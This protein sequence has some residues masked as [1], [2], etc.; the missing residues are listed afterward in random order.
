MNQHASAAMVAELRSFNRFYTRQV[1]LVS[2]GHLGSPWSLTEG[3][4][5]YE[6]LSAGRRET[7][8]L[9][10]AL[11]IDPAQL[12]RVL[13]RL[14]QGGLLTRAP[15]PDDGRRQTVALTT[16]GGRAAALLDDR[17]N[18]A[19]REQLD[20]LRPA[21]RNRL[22]SGMAEIRRILGDGAGPPPATVLLRPVR[23]GDLGWVVERHAVLY[24]AEYGWDHT[25]EGLI[26]EVVADYARTADPNRVA[27]WIAEL[28]GERVGSVFCVRKDDT[29]AKL[30]LLL[31]E[32]AARGHRIGSRLVDTCM[33]F[34]RTAGYK[35]MTL[36]TNDVLSSARHIYQRA[37]FELVHSEEHR[38]F[39]ADLVG[40]TWER[41][42]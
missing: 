8:E 15:S 14:E 13:G 36:W 5:L 38:S 33:D 21:D 27:G 19:M 9:R 35:R 6:L 16:A 2:P 4:I 26:A 23:P 39:G 31:V 30:R 32:P 25:Y 24:A 41:D 20:R 18:A 17:S 7:V 11:D 3:R 1:G 10:D 34:A 42:L 12:S 28:D 29:T 22:L 37:G 40:Q